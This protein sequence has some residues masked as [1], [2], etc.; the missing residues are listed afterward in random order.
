[1]ISETEI[2]TFKVLETKLPSALSAL[3]QIPA[4]RNMQIALFKAFTEHGSMLFSIYIVV[5]VQ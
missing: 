4:T 1:M 3:D 2:A 5:F